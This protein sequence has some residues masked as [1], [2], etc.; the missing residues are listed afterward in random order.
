MTADDVERLIELMA[1]GSPQIERMDPEPMRAFFARVQ[2]SAAALT[3]EQASA[4]I[5]E[6]A[7][8][9]RA[10]KP[11]PLAGDFLARLDEL[12]RG[13]QRTEGSS[14]REWPYGLRCR[15]ATIHPAASSGGPFGWLR[16]AFDACGVTQ[17]DA[18][19]LLTQAERSA[20]DAGGDETLPQQ[21]LAFE[22]ALAGL[23]ESRGVDLR[24]VCEQAE[25]ERESSRPPAASE[26]RVTLEQIRRDRTP[27]DARR[28]VE[29]P[30]SRAR[31]SEQGRQG[32]PI[33][34]SH[35]APPSEG[36]GKHHGT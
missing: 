22:A 6:L 12:S 29:R 4:A 18:A 13:R 17:A 28:A 19:E 14:Y 7:L 8:S 9:R 1:A 34:S 10:G 2:R 31:A 33:G 27:P 5:A 15:L 21:R 20:A 30:L 32:S 26:D 3:F 24:A 23:A 35:E 11:A 36:A 16:R 25:A